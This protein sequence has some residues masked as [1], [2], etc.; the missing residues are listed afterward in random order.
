ME[1]IAMQA[2]GKQP[3]DLMSER[4]ILGLMM[5]DENE[6]LYGLEKLSEKDFFDKANSLIFA[7]MK[8]VQKQGNKIDEITIGDYLQTTG[9]L[10]LVGGR[11]YLNEL[12]GSAFALGKLDSYVNIVSQKSQLRS[13]MRL[14]QELI[15]EAA[16]STDASKVLEKAERE[17]FNISTGRKNL[18]FVKVSKVMEGIIKDLQNKK[19]DRSG[20]TGVDTGFSNM[21]FKLSGFQKSDLIILAA[22][23]SV[24]KTALALNF[25]YNAAIKGKVVGIFSL[26]M[27]KEQMALRMLAR[28]AMVELN[29]IK[30]GELKPDDFEVIRAALTI[31]RESKFFI[32]EAPG[33][34]ITE[35][36]SQARKLKTQNHSLD[37]I[38]IDYLQLMVGEGESQQVMVSN[39][40]RSLKALAMELDCP[41]IALSQL[42]RKAED[43]KNHRPMLS[44]LRDSGSIEQDADVV[45]LLYRE[46]YY[47]KD[48]I[49]NKNTAELDIAKH[50]NGETGTVHLHWRPE[51]QLFR[52]VEED[53]T[54][55]PEPY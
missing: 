7:A 1:K 47:D 3:S 46:A 24:G 20:L 30:R 28:A 53:D 17:I 10:V 38:V 31:F 21:N 19:E 43:R 13:I 22:R 35:I 4:A 37:L 15:S 6:A 42:S 25:A 11:N 50:R 23:P 52:A 51:F 5:L 41:V 26:E 48:N 12:T 14:S 39:I 36:R 27:S 16:T 2:G 44:D 32:S 45:M 9:T 54:R 33:A 40:S 18:D 49:E 34:T 55:Y 8:E 29:D